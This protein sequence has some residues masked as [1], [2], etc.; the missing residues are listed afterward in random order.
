MKILIAEDDQISRRLLEATLTTWGY[1]VQVTCDGRTACQALEAKEPPQMA[2]LDWMMPEMDGLEICHQVRSTPAGRAIYIILLTARTSKEDVIAGLD[3]GADD[4]IT[5]PFNREELGARLRAGRRIVE[6]QLSLAERMAELEESLARIKHLN[7]LLPMCAWCKK[8]RDDQ[9]YWQEVES[10]VA[11]HSD[12]RFT[13]GICP[14]CTEKM[15]AGY[16]IGGLN[17]ARAS[18]VL[19]SDAL[20]P[21]AL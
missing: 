18:E 11:S 6:L 14:A 19:K 20:I 13:H 15:K 12:A 9:N 5:K 8:I 2:L 1:E 3:G 7:G 21:G 10:Y 16:A 17:A 4:Y